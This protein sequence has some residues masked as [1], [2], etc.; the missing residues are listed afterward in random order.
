MHRFL[1]L[2]P[3]VG[4]PIWTPLS[5]VH[6]ILYLYDAYVWLIV[7]GSAAVNFGGHLIALYIPPPRHD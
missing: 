3:L 6:G 4:S 2:S 1:G 5:T 7:G